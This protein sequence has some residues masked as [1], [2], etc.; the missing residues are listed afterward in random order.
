MVDF[1]G[2]VFGSTGHPATSPRLTD[3]RDPDI[4]FTNNIAIII[5]T[6]PF[7]VSKACILTGNGRSLTDLDLINS[8]MEGSILD[9][10]VRRFAVENSDRLSSL[11]GYRS[12]R[13]FASNMV[14]PEYADD[15]IHWNLFDGDSITALVL[16][17]EEYMVLPIVVVIDGNMAQ[18][19]SRAVS[20]DA[21]ITWLKWSG[22]AHVLH[23]IQNSIGLALVGDVF[24][25]A[26]L[27]AMN[28]FPSVIML[29]HIGG[30]IPAV[31]MEMVV[32]I[33]QVIS[34]KI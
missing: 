26:A 16:T 8:N 22:K 28:G 7:V 34:I 17:K 9:M 19:A 5:D 30:K 32:P 14:G 6:H 23:E 2:A 21:D 29:H 20:P 10:E 15:S 3:P 25:I 31:M 1:T 27:A 13:T 4:T 18:W 12:S 33:V 24:D 11:F